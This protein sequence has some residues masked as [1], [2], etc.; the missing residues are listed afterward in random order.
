MEVSTLTEERGKLQ[1]AVK[2]LEREMAALRREVKHRDDI[3]KDR[4]SVC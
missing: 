3:I 1:A 4:V 2:A